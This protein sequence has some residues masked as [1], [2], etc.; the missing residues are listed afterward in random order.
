MKK[1][2][3]KKKNYTFRDLDTTG[4]L[5]Y[6][7]LPSPVFKHS[8]DRYHWYLVLSF[9][10]PIIEILPLWQLSHVY[11]FWWQHSASVYECGLIDLV[12]DNWVV[13]FSFFAI[14]NS[15]AVHI[16]LFL[17]RYR[18]SEL[19]VYSFSSRHKTAPCKQSPEWTLS[20]QEEGS[21]L[22]TVF[23]G[24]Q[25]AHA[26]WPSPVTAAR[27]PEDQWW[28]YRRLHRHIGGIPF[29]SHHS[30]QHTLPKASV[31]SMEERLP[32][33]VWE[34]NWSSESPRTQGSWLHSQGAQN[35]REQERVWKELGTREAVTSP[36]PGFWLE[37]GLISGPVL[38][39]RTGS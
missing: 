7:Q 30:R 23:T 32:L 2:L 4:S 14:I 25:S 19:W 38:S 20:Y 1:I 16:Y 6:T 8:R 39:S 9:Q 35:S 18:M 11:H 31:Y 33:S 10:H 24:F 36:I 37:L 3:E 29:L 5:L 17:S 21:L 13:P 34:P 26:L 15:T 12:L 27:L 28:A 22:R